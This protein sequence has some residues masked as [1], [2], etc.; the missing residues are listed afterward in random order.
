MAVRYLAKRMRKVQTDIEKYFW[1]LL[2]SRQISGYKFYRQYVLQKQTVDFLCREAKVAILIS[3]KDELKNENDYPCVLAQGYTI[4]IF[5]EHDILNE[6][7]KTI[8]AIEQALLTN[9][10]HYDLVVS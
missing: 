3:Y 2:R 4:L 1:S 10:A 9:T 6:T 8:N 5:N 7:D